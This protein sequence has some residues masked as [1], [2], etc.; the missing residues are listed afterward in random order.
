[1]RLLAE[2]ILKDAGMDARQYESSYQ[3]QILTNLSAAVSAAVSNAQ[4]LTHIGL[5]EAQVHKVASNRRIHGPD[6]KVRAVRY[7]RDDQSGASGGTRRRHRSHGVL[8]SFWKR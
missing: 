1:L 6:G 2:K 7:T 4:P 5:G 3:R 8:V